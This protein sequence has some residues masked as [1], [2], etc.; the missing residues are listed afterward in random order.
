MEV[1]ASYVCVTVGSVGLIHVVVTVVG[2]H[3]AGVVNVGEVPLV[4]LIPASE[5]DIVVGVLRAAIG[6]EL[7]VH[8]AFGSGYFKFLRVD[9]VTFVFAHEG[10]HV[11]GSVGHEVHE[12]CSDNVVVDFALDYC[13]VDGGVGLQAVAVACVGV[14]SIGAS[15]EVGAERNVGSSYLGS[16]G[17]CHGHVLAID[18]D[19]VV[20]VVAGA[21][22]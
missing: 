17:H 15:V 1:S 2:F 18:K 7:L 5:V 21:H 6:S 16:F 20:I 12:S 4:A 10:L 9:G 14:D 19:Y 3:D 22:E 8:S 13:T 11:V